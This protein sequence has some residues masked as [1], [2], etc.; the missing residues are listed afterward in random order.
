MRLQAFLGLPVGTPVI[1]ILEHCHSSTRR[2]VTVFQH[3]GLGVAQ[4]GANED[5]ERS[6]LWSRWS[7]GSAVNGSTRPVADMRGRRTCCVGL[8]SGGNTVT[9]NELWNKRQTPRTRRIQ[10]AQIDWKLFVSPTSS[11]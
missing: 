5:T 10:S 3:L 7:G 8:K 2:Q 9:H 6:Q 11:T 4:T 1:L